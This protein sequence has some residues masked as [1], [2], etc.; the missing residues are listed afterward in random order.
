MKPPKFKNPNEILSPWKVMNVFPESRTERGRILS[1]CLY[2]FANSSYSA[3]IAAVVFPVYFTQVV[4]GNER[5]LGD[6]WWGRAISFSMALVAVSSPFLGGVADHTGLRRSFLRIY[7]LLSVGAVASFALLQPGMVLAGFTLVTLANFGMEGAL[8]FYNAY[9]PDV[10]PQGYQGR[11]SAWGFALGYAGSAISLLIALPFVQAGQYSNVWW[12]VSGFFAVFSL[13]LLLRPYSRGVQG[14]PGLIAAAVKGFEDTLVSIRYLSARKGPV[15]FLISYFLYEDGVNTVIVFSSIF[16]ATTLGFR[17]QE[18]VLLY[19]VVQIT[20]L[21]GAVGMASPI[22]RWG[23]LRVVRLSLALWLLVTVAASLIHSKTAFWGIAIT[24]GLGLGTI[25]AASRALYLA[26]IPPGEE[27]RYFGVY[28][29]IGKTSAILGPL[30]F[31]HVSS[32][33]GSQRPAV[34]AVGLFFLAGGFLLRGVPAPD[35]SRSGL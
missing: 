35:P 26:Y 33:T 25:Q 27:A 14:K 13:P 20:A 15:R 23:P 24:A 10:A 34:L 12:M 32:L 11:V 8:V 3:V 19:L 1:W 7:T 17:P 2:D 21:T 29:M 18:L 28:A 4:V 31:G 6:L 9:L 5:G 16:A 30:L 22:D